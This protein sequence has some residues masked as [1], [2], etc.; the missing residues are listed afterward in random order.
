MRV[1]NAASV[2]VL[3]V[4]CSSPGERPATEEERPARAEGSA[5]PEERPTGED[6]SPA[7]AEGITCGD[8][9]PPSPPDDAVLVYFNCESAAP[10]AL[11]PVQRPVP[12]SAAASPEARLEAA[13]RALVA[14]PTAD[15]R[16][17]GFRSFF[18]AD[19]GVRLLDARVSEA[20]DT[21]WLDFTSFEGRLPDGPGVR[22]FVPP[23]VMAELTW[24]VFRS[25]PELEAVRFAFEGSESAFWSWVGG[26]VEVFTRRDW[27]QI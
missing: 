10:G 18:S 22:S 23:G 2:L 26:P 21:A 25:S 11:T 5:E 27:E 15:E 4:A 12:D 3:L 19:A 9:Q 13:I 24:T 20:G 16:E 7:P 8:P 6:A 17:R 14:G 1:L